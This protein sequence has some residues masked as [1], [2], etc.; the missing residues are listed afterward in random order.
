MQPYE[1]I[2]K[3][4]DERVFNEKIIKITK[5]GFG[6]NFREKCVCLIIT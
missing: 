1:I 2:V 5:L 6:R 4:A 3:N